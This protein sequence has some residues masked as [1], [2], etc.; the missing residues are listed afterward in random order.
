M[1]NILDNHFGIHQTTLRLRAARAQVLS[2]NLVNADTPNYKARDIDFAQALAAA[3]NDFADGNTLRVTDTA[4]ISPAAMDSMSEDLA[5]RN[6]QQAS[7]DGNTVDAEAEKT[8][9][10][11]NS[12]QY[13]VSLKFLDGKI[14]TLMAAIKGE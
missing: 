2:E 8:E 6:P 10:L 3:S 1:S 13:Q 5:Y 7:L 14:R 12:L 11:R 9:F 4:H